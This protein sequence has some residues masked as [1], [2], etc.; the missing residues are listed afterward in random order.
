MKIT[1]TA[2]TQL[3]AS[4]DYYLSN[5]T[6][7]IKEAGFWQHFKCWTGW[8]DGRAK[9][10]RLADAIKTALLEDA[11]IK[12]EAKL[13]A[14]LDGLDK[15]RSLLGSDLRQIASRFKADHAQAIATSDACRVAET[16]VDEQ[17]KSWVERGD[18]LPEVES[19]K[20]LKKLCLYAAQQVTDD[21]LPIINDQKQLSRK[22][23]RNLDQMLVCLNSAENMKKKDVGYPKVEKC[24]DANGKTR[25]LNPPRFRLDELHF[26]AILGLMATK[27]GPATFMT[28]IMALVKGLP[29]AELQKR[30]EA[31]LKIPLAKPTSPGSGVAFAAQVAKSHELYNA[32]LVNGIKMANPR[33]LPAAFNEAEEAVVAEMRERFGSEVITNNTHANSLIV[34]NEHIAIV[35]ALVANA[36]AEGR[37]VGTEEVKA[38]IREKCL[39]GAAEAVLNNAFKQIAAERGLPPPSVSQAT[40]YAKM[41]P[42]V[43]ADI[44][45]CDTPEAA[46]AAARR[47]EDDIVAKMQLHIDAGN[48]RAEL[49]ARAAA[50]IAESTGM[51]VAYIVARLNTDKLLDKAR[52]VVDNI[53]AGKVEGVGKPG[54]DVK[55]AFKGVLDNFVNSRL[56]IMKEI[57]NLDGLSDDLKRKWKNLVIS[58]YKAEKLNPAKIHKLLACGHFSDKMLVDALSAD[59]T[60]AAAEKICSYMGS[61]NAHF[62][63]LFGQEEWEDMGNDERVPVLNMAL[64]GVMDK[65]PSIAEKFLARSDELMGSLNTEFDRPEFFAQGDGRK[66]VE[67]LYTILVGV[68]GQKVGGERTR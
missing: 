11:A 1:A 35:E 33:F 15:T 7:T 49:P 39:R 29:E 18:V 4:K 38:A 30:K 48:A 62:V 10:A 26:R 23:R 14:E 22:I 56:A 31:I 36:N 5:T 25:I 53:D 42:G 40:Q 44:V 24:T 54:F 64:L 20:Y 28:F 50:M 46:L 6:G 66:V 52:A 12:S 65:N 63:E 9:A 67:G 19:L 13:T 37:T 68:D 16:I 21:A 27:D 58:T 47:H 61:V 2:L 59:G 32:S 45:A 8:G 51:D 60:A 55:A 3:D 43:V 41:N 57:D 17:M 34:Y